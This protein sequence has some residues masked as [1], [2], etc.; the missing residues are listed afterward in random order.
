MEYGEECRVGAN[1]HGDR[2]DRDK[3]DAGTLAQR[4]ERGDEVGHITSVCGLSDSSKNWRPRFAVPLTGPRNG[5]RQDAF[6]PH[7]MD[8]CAPMVP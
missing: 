6:R 2:Q 5:P 7:L 8:V 4:P 1:A 3:G